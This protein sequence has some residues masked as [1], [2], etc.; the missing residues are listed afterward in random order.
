M[1]KYINGLIPLV[2][3]CCM[4]SNALA[5]GLNLSWVNAHG[6][7][8][9]DV[10]YDF[11]R[12]V[13]GNI[14][15]TGVF[16]GTIDFDSGPDTL[17]LIGSGNAG[18]IFVQKLDPN[19]NLLWTHA[20]A[21]YNGSTPS[22]GRSITVD[23]SGNVLVTGVFSGSNV[24][25]D[26]GPGQVL[27]SSS[28]EN[29]FILKLDGLGNFLWVA[30][31]DDDFRIRGE[32]IRTDPLGNIY[33]CGSFSGSTDFDPSPGGQAILSTPGGNLFKDI[34]VLKLDPNGN[35]I[36]AKNIGGNEHDAAGDLVLDGAGN[37]CVAGYFRSTVDFDPGP[38]V[39]S[40]TTGGEEDIF[41]MKLDPG[42]G[43]FFLSAGIGQD[44]YIQKV[45][46]NGN[47]MYAEL[48][49]SADYASEY[50]WT[51]DA[52]NQQNVYVCGGYS[53]DADFNPGLDTVLVNGYGKSDIFVAKFSPCNNIFTTFNE[54]ICSNQLPYNFGGQSILTL[55]TYTQ[56][57]P[58]SNGCDSVVSLTLSINPVITT[59]L[60]AT[61]CDPA[62]VGKDTLFLLGTEGCDSLVIT[63]TNLLPSYSSN[64]TAFICQGQSYLFDGQNLTNSGTYT[65]NLQSTGGCDSIL[66]L[67]L[68]V[69]N[70]EIQQDRS[71][72][73]PD[74][75][76]YVR[77]QRK[78]PGVW[79]QRVHIQADG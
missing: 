23:A 9:Y 54:S 18:D 69:G 60:S 32:G 31:F 52:D 48:I 2:V 17:N 68:T 21:V 62:Q 6:G 36:W 64:D 47:F 11:V 20:I 35:Y 43:T 42:P 57:F 24:D 22:F 45:D 66:T 44:I 55:G 12:D 33:T 7:T 79:L 50:G 34:F 61:S 74:R 72:H 30:T 41:V 58:A 10:A 29:M 65:A 46:S 77:R 1:K 76:R 14:Y 39:V 4:F 49:K 38:G 13:S 16:V 37:V 51:I 59:N 53:G 25:F 28:G 3:F 26:P 75:L 63:T 5:Q 56:T 27:K 78:D 71:H 19:G 15:L 67:V 73:R 70:Q 40:L 8:G